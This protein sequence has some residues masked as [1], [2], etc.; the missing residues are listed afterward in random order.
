MV[1][2]KLLISGTV[3]YN[4]TVIRY[5]TQYSTIEYYVQMIDQYLLYYPLPVALGSKG[6]CTTVHNSTV[7]YSTSIVLD[8]A[9][10]IYSTCT[11]G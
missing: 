5:C 8:G 1:L 4:S 6:K 10:R 9:D 3:Q 2:Y 11:A 7:R